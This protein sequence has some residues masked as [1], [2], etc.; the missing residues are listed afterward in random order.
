MRILAED[1]ESSYHQTGNSHKEKAT[2]AGFWQAHLT[3]LE[4]HSDGASVGVQ[5]RA[6]TDPVELT[7]RFLV[8][9]LV[10]S[11]LSCASTEALIEECMDEDG[12]SA[13]DEM[14]EDKAGNN[15]LES[16]VTTEH[17][18][19]CVVNTVFR[20]AA[21]TSTLRGALASNTKAAAEQML[22]AELARAKNAMDTRIARLPPATPFSQAKGTSNTDPT[23]QEQIAEIK[24]AHAVRVRA[25]ERRH[26]LRLRVQASRTAPIGCDGAGRVYW[27]F[28]PWASS[29][30]AAASAGTGEED[31]DYFIVTPAEDATSLAEENDD[32]MDLDVELVDEQTDN[33][34]GVPRNLQCL[35]L[36]RDNLQILI[37]WLRSEQ[38]SLG[39]GS[40]A[41][42]R[43]LENYAKKLLAMTE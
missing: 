40:S 22:K 27:H 10:D 9:N 15:P 18:W 37:A 20:L 3:T 41:E 32:K 42:V 23:R 5:A 8:E 36:T 14:D 26:N 16:L 39:A 6:E 2:Q 1:G 30:A 25:V 7:R 4:K 19:L 11:G 12:E 24:Q 33:T 28:P 35:S 29:S 34:S 38:T 13:T 31:Y 43:R 17:A 21:Q